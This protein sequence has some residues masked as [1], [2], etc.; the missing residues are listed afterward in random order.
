MPLLWPFHFPIFLGPFQWFFH[1]S[2]KHDRRLG[3]LSLLGTWLEASW[4]LAQKWNKTWPLRHLLY[5]VILFGIILGKG[6]WYQF[7]I[8]RQKCLIVSKT[9]IW[10]PLRVR[11]ILEF[12]GCSVYSGQQYCH[13][14]CFQ[15]FV[16]SIQRNI[17]ASC[18][19]ELLLLLVFSTSSKVVIYVRFPEILQA[20]NWN[21]QYCVSKLKLL[22]LFNLKYTRLPLDNYYSTLF[23]YSVWQICLPIELL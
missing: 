3:G 7:L 5:K 13:L 9:F 14:V 16:Y 23:P 12:H 2:R 11:S 8:P 1:P 17:I 6:C 15:T 18:Y 4:S 22:Y 10:K 19:Y 20:V 21:E